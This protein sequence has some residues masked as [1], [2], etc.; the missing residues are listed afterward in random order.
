MASWGGRSRSRVEAFTVVEAHGCVQQGSDLS[1]AS[2]QS[3]VTAPRGNRVRTRCRDDMK[4]LV[5]GGADG[6]TRGP[7]VAW[8]GV[9]EGK[10]IDDD[11]PGATSAARQGDAAL[12]GRPVT[13]FGVTGRGVEQHPYGGQVARSVSPHHRPNAYRNTMSEEYRY[14]S[15]RPPGDRPI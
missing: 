4:R 13:P 14:L 12:Q 2:G 5:V 15:V 6:I 11:Q 10:E 9:A 1:G 8:I 7:K 3:T